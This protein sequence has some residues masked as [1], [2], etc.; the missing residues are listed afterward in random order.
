ML[1]S[2]ANG[3]FQCGRLLAPASSQPPPTEDETE[4]RN[5]EEERIA[6]LRHLRKCDMRKNYATAVVALVLLAI[7]VYAVVDIVRNYILKLSKR[8]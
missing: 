4:M 2:I 5:R 6:Y 7:G 8:I 1:L 3:L